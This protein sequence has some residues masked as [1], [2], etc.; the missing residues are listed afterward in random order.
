MKRLIGILLALSLFLPMAWAAA[1]E[2]VYVI[3]DAAQADGSTAGQLQSDRS[4][5]RVGCRLQSETDVTLS[6]TG[7]DGS[8]VYQRSYGLCSGRFSSED[9]FLR[10]NGSQTDYRVALQAGDQCYAF[11]LRRVQPRMSGVSAC[12]AGYPLR[13]ITG[14]DTWRCA[15]VLDLTALEGASMTVPLL[16]GD[17]YE[18]GT[19]TFSAARGALTVS[20]CLNEGVD[21]S[22]DK[23]TVYVAETALEAKTLGKKSFSGLK[24]RLNQSLALADT[25]YAAV[26]VALTVS[27]DPQGVPEASGTQ[28]QGQEDVWQRMQT[29]TANEAIG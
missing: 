16:A 14:A 2:D 8:L 24:G 28:L 26:Y 18:I 7:E 10:L 13:S 9:I 23:G 11:S 1:G 29:E 25:S 12:S 22:I 3:A 6:V 27:F 15:T 21:G 19:V 4:Y 17:A 20:A 5:L